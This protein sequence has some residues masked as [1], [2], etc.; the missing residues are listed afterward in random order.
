MS[1]VTGIVSAISHDDADALAAEVLTALGPATAVSRCTVFV[2][3][4][5]HRPHP[6]SSADHRGG[7]FPRD[8]ADVYAR[9]F[10]ALDDNQRT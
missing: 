9:P 6:V 1:H 2:Y 10:Y 4:F 7:R 5:S 8:V 3:E